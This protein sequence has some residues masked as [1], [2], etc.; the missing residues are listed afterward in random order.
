MEIPAYT[1]DGH[2]YQKL[3]KTKHEENFYE[4]LADWLITTL[5]MQDTE[6]SNVYRIK[7]P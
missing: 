4:A 6:E 3:G 5:Y 7:I 1:K 2:L